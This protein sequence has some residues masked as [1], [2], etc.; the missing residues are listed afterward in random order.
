M[1]CEQCGGEKLEK[2][3]SG[4]SRIA[5]SVSS[6]SDE[7]VKCFCHR[8]TPRPIEPEPDTKQSQE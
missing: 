5:G 3:F 4:P 6:R 8:L 7:V 2:A 1:I